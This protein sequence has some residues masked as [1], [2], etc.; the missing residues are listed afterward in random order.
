MSPVSSFTILPWIQVNGSEEESIL[1]P[2][3]K[4]MFKQKSKF[5]NACENLIHGCNIDYHDLGN[6]KMFYL[7][8][9]H[10]LFNRHHHLFPL[11][12]CRRGAGIDANHECELLPHDQ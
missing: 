6:G 9:Q 10:S 4:N 3:L 5:E 1:F 7:L 2:C 8:C 11:C 12:K